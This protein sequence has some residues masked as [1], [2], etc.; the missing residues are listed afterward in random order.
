[1]FSSAKYVLG[2]AAAVSILAACSGGSQSGFAPT[3]GTPQGIAGANHVGAVNMV[4]ESLMPRARGVLSKIPI[5]PDAGSPDAAAKA[6]V[7][8]GSFGAS[9]I[10]GYTAANPH[11]KAPVCT[12]SGVSAVNGL[13]ADGVGNVIDPDGGSR[14]IIIFGPH[15][16]SS[17][18]TISDTFGQ[19]SDAT[20]AN[21][22]T[23]KIAV[24][25][26]LDAS[27]SFGSLMTCTVKSGCTNLTS[28]NITGYAGGVAMD[29][30]G[31]NCWITSENASFSAAVLTYYK[32]CKGAGAATTGFVNKSYGSLD[33][34]T[35]GNLVSIDFMNNAL[36]V[37]KGCNPKCTTVGGPF[38]LHGE[39]IFGKFNDTAKSFEAVEFSVGQVDVYTY[40]PTAV[41]YKYSYNNG[42]VASQQPEGVAFAPR[43][44]E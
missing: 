5:G 24:G 20:S 18:A 23:G 30:A 36:Y 37:Y 42:L 16:G 7:Y 35:A 38:T 33:I 44:D 39:S 14:S 41:T 27:Q 4:P 21:A 2:V 25:N 6:G 3:A 8:V 28:S 34:D 10:D 40:T 31:K 26:I 22:M 12:I 19:P 11:N 9:V 15:C 13:G 29:K 1:M 17:L 32:G 43:S